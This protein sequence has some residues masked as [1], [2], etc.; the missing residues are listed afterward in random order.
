MNDIQMQ[1]VA[2]EELE[3]VEG[4]GSLW[5]TI[6]I[7]EGTFISCVAGGGWAGGLVG[8]GLCGVGAVIME[9]VVAST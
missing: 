9:A 4:G 7:G 8:I 6:L 2:I 3:S 1:N 5:G